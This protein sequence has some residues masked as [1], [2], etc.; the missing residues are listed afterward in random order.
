MNSL[1]CLDQ[2]KNE[3]GFYVDIEAIIDYLEDNAYDQ[4][5]INKIIIQLI[6]L[7]EQ[8]NR[9]MQNEIATL[10]S[11]S[12]FN[13]QTVVEV[14]PSVD[15]EVPSL[16][17][18][19]KLINVDI[20]LEMLDELSDDASLD[21][22]CDSLDEILPSIYDPNYND[23][24][25]SILLNLFI[26]I[27][28][29]RELLKVFKDDGAKEDSSDVIG[30]KDFI[31]KYDTLIHAI[32]KFD[33]DEEKDNKDEEKEDMT[34][35]K[36][37]IDKKCRIIY[38]FNENDTNVIESDLSDIAVEDYKAT[39]YLLKDILEQRNIKEKRFRNHDDF[40][41]LSCYR[42]RNSRVLFVRLSNDLI[43][44]LGVFS[45]RCQS[46]VAYKEFISRRNKLYHSM[47]QLIQARANDEK[48]M[49]DND[50]FTDTFLDIVSP[51]WGDTLC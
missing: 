15:I 50:D 3:H 25:K 22:L 10:T 13:N 12:H 36:H 40:K 26:I 31:K 1:D 2:F 39:Y 6:D 43:V 45:K 33:E 44:V 42:K 8:N 48:F 14:K 21:D 35:E 11:K 27:S 5:D 47:E 23:I 20:Y 34:S 38:L 28:E 18:Q 9:K 30:C 32:K 16:N 51:D 4:E 19:T 49:A 46:P 24:I 7:N 17:C 29:Y 41:G 37:T